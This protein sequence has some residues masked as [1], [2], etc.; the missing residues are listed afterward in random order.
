MIMPEQTSHKAHAGAVASAL[1]AVVLAVVGVVPTTE[2]VLA[3]DL[4]ALV[5]AVSALILAAVVPWLAT[6]FTPNRPKP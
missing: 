6:Y 1:I 2:E 4:T 5:E 3:A